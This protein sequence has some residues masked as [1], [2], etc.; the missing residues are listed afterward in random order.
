MFDVLLV[1][2]LIVIVIVQLKVNDDVYVFT[3]TPQEYINNNLICL[4]DKIK[5]INVKYS[6]R[7]WS[8]NVDFGFELYLYIS[9]KIANN[10]YITFIIKTVLC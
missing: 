6:I 4:I 5:N 9:T 10:K 2:K 3:L 7:K 8:L 1:E